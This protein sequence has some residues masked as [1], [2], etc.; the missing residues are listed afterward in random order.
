MSDERYTVLV[1]EDEP[2]LLRLVQFRLELE[3]YEVR[4]ATDG[5]S[6]LESVYD[7]RP[8][9]CLLDVVMPRRSGWD[10]LREL[11]SD[12]R[13]RDLKVIMLT[14]RATDGR[15]PDRHAARRRRL[16]HQAV[17]VPGPAGTRGGA[18]AGI[19]RTAGYRPSADGRV[20]QDH[21]PAG[22]ARR[23]PCGVRVRRRLHDRHRGGVRDPRAGRPEHGRRAS[24]ASTPPPAPGPLAGMVAGELIRSE[25]EVRTGRC[26]SFAEAAETTGAAAG[27]PA[28]GVRAARLPAVG[29]RARTRSRAGR[30]RRSS[31]PP[32]TTWS[33]RRCA[34]S[35]GATTR[36]ASTSTPASAGP[37]G[38]SRWRARC[39]RCCPSSWRRRAARRG[40]RAAT[41]TCTRPGRRS[42]PASFPRC[43][44]PD[45][46]AGWDEYAA[47]VRFLIATRSIREHTEIWWSVRP[48]QAFPTVEIRIC[49]AQ[50]E[51][52]RAVALSGPHGGALGALRAPLRRGPAAAGAPGQAARGEPVAGDPVGH[53]R[54]ADR[55]RRRPVDAGARAARGAG[56]GGVRGRVRARHHAPPGPALRADRRRAVRRRPGGGGGSGGGVAARRR[57]DARVG[58]GMACAS[59]RRRRDERCRADRPGG[60]RRVHA[61]GAGAGRRRLAGADGL[62]RRLPAHGPSGRWGRRARSRP[63]A[64]LRSRRCA[65]SCRCSS[66]CSTSSR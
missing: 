4:T 19:A 12:E 5:E 44:I 9:V 25:V 42:S 18:P 65:R 13:G 17:L 43:G 20:T 39:A 24:S 63:D 26:E 56:G 53:V 30:T 31:T 37:T 35:P 23:R 34:T 62:R 61:H 1:A 55:P 57:A 6:A 64:S 11:R 40:S 66:R 59:G 8:D 58:H 52:D 51:F 49:D 22:C 15:H 48:H 41:P 47:F 27:R 32:T 21:R 33:S 50:P 38:R 28:G 29:R 2:H 36:S 16:H 14:A 60:G 46:F 45:R 54:R 3:G 7:R 10:V